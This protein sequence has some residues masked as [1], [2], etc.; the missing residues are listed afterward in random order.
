MQIQKLTVLAEAGAVRTVE[1]IPDEGGWAVWIT[2]AHHG[3]ERR[4]A[5]ERQRGGERAFA[6][7]DAVARALGAAGID[8]FRVSLRSGEG[9][10]GGR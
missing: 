9:S 4:E 10:S 8:E 6:T 5:L 3:G 7:L 2:R 1:A